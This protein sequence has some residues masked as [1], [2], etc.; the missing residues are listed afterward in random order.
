MVALLFSTL[1]WWIDLASR[2][3]NVGMVLRGEAEDAISLLEALMVRGALIGGA[4]GLLFGLGAMSR[5][6]GSQRTIGETGPEARK[7]KR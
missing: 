2:G 4:V 6:N 3:K 7:G 5:T 1:L